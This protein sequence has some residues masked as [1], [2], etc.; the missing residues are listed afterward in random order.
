MQYQESGAD[1]ISY[2]NRFVYLS[3]N[4]TGGNSGLTFDGSMGI[5][6]GNSVTVDIEENIIVIPEIDFNHEVGITGAPCDGPC[7]GGTAG[8]G[9]GIQ[10]E[11]RYGSVIKVHT[12][13]G[14]AGFTGEFVDS[15]TFGFTIIL[16]GNYIWA[17][18]ENIYFKSDNTVFSCGEDIINFM[19]DD[20]GDTWNA[21]VSSIGYGIG[22]EGCEGGVVP[23]GSCCYVDGSGDRQCIEYTTKEICDNKNEGIW[24]SLS[25]CSEN[26]GF[27]ADGVCCSHG[28]DWGNYAGT[29]ICISGNGISEC[30]YFSGTFLDYYYYEEAM[31]PD[32]SDFYMKELDVPVPI[33][34]GGRFPCLDINDSS[35]IEGEGL[36][37]GTGLS[38][39]ICA[40]PC[41]TTSCCKDGKC[42]GD[43]VGS[44]SL[45]SISS[46]AC[47][48][49][50]GLSLIHI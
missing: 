10:L 48:Y 24:N 18:P 34:C 22:G 49:V 16:D 27:T 13:T 12:P 45:G 28:G 30:N 7:P 5:D 25:S 41:D 44:T 23:I 39:D 14:I 9:T 15:E 2:A 8:N 1:G 40:S 50:Y 32:G 20:G 42:I 47:R 37:K 36:L 4:G 43:S 11:V 17:W 21:T 35:C 19:T 26:C 6:F 31:T 46:A 3:E 33:E 29:G 38:N